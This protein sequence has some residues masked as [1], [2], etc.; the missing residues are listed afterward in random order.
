MQRPHLRTLLLAALLCVA[1]SA[2]TATHVAKDRWTV[3][4]SRNFRVV[5]N[6]QDERSADLLRD[7]EK[8]RA[9]M[10]S[11]SG[12][13]TGSEDPLTVYAFNNRASFEPFVHSRWHQVGFYAYDLAGRYA[14]LDVSEERSKQ[15]LFRQYV[16]ALL[17]SSGTLYPPWYHEGLP[18]FLGTARVSPDAVELGRPPQHWGMLAL[19]KPGDVLGQT[20]SHLRRKLTEAEELDIDL[21]R[22]WAIVDFLTLGHLTQGVKDRRE[23]LAHFLTLWNAGEGAA[24][25]TK[26]FGM[27]GA[28]L[29]AEMERWARRGDFPLIRMPLETGKQLSQLKATPLPAENV[30]MELALVSRNAGQCEQAL[31]LYGM[32]LAERP[33]HLEARIGTA[34]CHSLEGRHAEAG[35]LF[36]ALA[37]EAPGSASLAAQQARHLFR[38]IGEPAQQ[39]APPAGAPRP[40]STPAGG[41]SREALLAEV[42]PARERLREALTQHPDDVE[43]LGLYGATFRFEPAGAD[44]KPAIASLERAVRKAPMSVEANGWLAEL[45][46]AAGEPEGARVYFQ[47]ILGEDGGGTAGA[48]AAR[49]L[50]KLQRGAEARTTE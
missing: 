43:L 37:R 44:L 24:A 22:T 11:L 16:R 12:A 23:E 49:E 42:G 17:A 5:S 2:C 6:L 45:L 3:T 40:A 1:G 50:E 47:R 9:V 41:P 8:F 21:A 39:E 13:A 10:L 20:G 48:W 35:A 14:A 27:S 32:V 31:S 28:E 25:Y 18:R 46:V 15:V 34:A 38:R 26:A 7:L 30:A 29:F 4:R 36:A 33:S 19:A